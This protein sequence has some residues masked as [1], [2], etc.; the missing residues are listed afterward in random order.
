MDER[1]KLSQTAI[2]DAVDGDVCIF[3]A[4][5]IGLCHLLL[6][7]HVG[8]RS[9]HMVEPLEGR[10]R[11]QPK[12]DLRRQSFE[13]LRAK[14]GKWLSGLEPAVLTL[15][16]AALQGSRPNWVEVAASWSS[17]VPGRSSPLSEC[18]VRGWGGLSMLK[19][20][21]LSG[22]PAGLCGRSVAFQSQYRLNAPGP[23]PKLQRLHPALLWSSSLGF[24]RW[25]TCPTIRTWLARRS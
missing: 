13:L 7:K 25:T 22:G 2:L 15:A 24:R 11:A 1:L 20:K 19:T 3:G 21:E 8:A 9:V 17:T 18:V 4:G 14:D 10:R 5:A 23:Q 16:K 12:I 6:L